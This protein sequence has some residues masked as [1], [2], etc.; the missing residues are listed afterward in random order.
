[1]T[2]EKTDVDEIFSN[3]FSPDVTT[4]EERCSEESLFKYFYFPDA[5]F[6]KAY[7][8]APTIKFAQ[9]SDL[10]DPFELTKRW[11]QF[12]SKL[13]HETFAKYIKSQIETHLANDDYIMESILES[14]EYKASGISK[15]QILE[16]I[17][18]PQGRQFLGALKANAIA[19]AQPVVELMFSVMESKSDEMIEKVMR[20][21]GILSLTETSVNKAMWG[22]YANSGYGFSIEYYAQHD[23]FKREDKNGKKVNLLRKVFYRDD[24]IEEFWKNPFYLFLV[25]NTDFS[26]EREWRMLCNIKDCTK[27]DI[28]EDRSIYVKD[29]PKGLIKSIIFGH[30]YDDNQ[31]QIEASYL[32]N[33]DTEIALK[34]V[35]AD[36]ATG[37]FRVDQVTL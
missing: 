30:R 20:T 21:T 5:G 14:D 19:Q 18:S 3:L 26:F 23:F 17:R 22:L 13:T 1:M 4:M 36:T 37:E 16:K 27:V 12:G 15:R 11:Q 10:N 25:K 7:L 24:R 2:F 8:S 35:A 29:A 31:I 9:K 32:R 6:R 28:S 33:F 34:K